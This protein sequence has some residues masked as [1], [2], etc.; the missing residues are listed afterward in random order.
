KD[1]RTRWR[2]TPKDWKNASFYDEYRKV[3][4]R[5]LRDTSTS[6]APW[7]VVEGADARYGSVTVARTLLEAMKK[8]LEQAPDGRAVP[9][10]PPP[11]VPRVDEKNVL[12]ALDLA[13]SLAN[14]GYE[15]ELERLQGKLNALSRS[16]HF[17]KLAVVVVFEG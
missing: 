1:P 5:A 9:G 16:K 15:D 7:I 6:H 4:E 2:V 14:E 3:D 13:K 8:R 12:L 17:R 11:L 10:R